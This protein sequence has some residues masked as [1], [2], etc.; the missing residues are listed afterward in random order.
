MAG[1]VYTIE[2]TYFKKKQK[3]PDERLMK[4]LTSQD[5]DL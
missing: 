3:L 2:N 4:F 5:K 1:I